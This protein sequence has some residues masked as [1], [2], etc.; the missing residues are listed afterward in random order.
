MKTRIAANLVQSTAARQAFAAASTGLIIELAGWIV[1]TF[2]AG[3]KLLLFGN[4]GS[5]ADAQHM[6]AEFVNR[7]MIDRRPLPAIALTTDS[8]VLTSIGNDF[9]FDLVFVKQVQALGKPGDLALAI[10]T[11]GRSPNVVR[12]LAAAR[13]MGMRTAALTGGTAKPGGDL[14]P[15]ADLLLNVPT[16]S[17]PHIQETH[18]WVEHMVCELVEME[19]FG[20]SRPA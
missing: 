1:E 3:G 5:A 9:G 19:M 17:T 4:G 7:F 14:G 12:A 10:S 8:S 11:S 16:D 2:R 15:V 13:E 6:A 20:D 18:L